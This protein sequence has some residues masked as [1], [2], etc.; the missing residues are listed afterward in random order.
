MGCAS[1]IETTL[2]KNSSIQLIKNIPEALVNSIIR[3]F[4]NDPGSKLKFLS[5][6]EVW[7]VILFF[8]I[9]VYL[10]KKLNPEEKNVV[11]TLLI[12]ALILS[13]LIGWT[14]PV[15]GA[16]TRYRF[17]AQFAIILAGL[18]LLKPLKLIKW[19]NMFS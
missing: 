9:T 6:I 16:I 17:P 2:I 18:I 5:F 7:I 8:A 12:F 4:P 19:K 3:P 10:R 11:F 15:L 14:T 1:F 13:L